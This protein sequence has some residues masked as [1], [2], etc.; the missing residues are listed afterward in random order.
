MCE[1]AA[2]LFLS[3]TKQMSLKLYKYYKFYASKNYLRN[4]KF[5]AAQKK[6]IVSFMHQKKMNKIKICRV[7]F[8][9]LS[10]NLTF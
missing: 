8:F 10:E 6:K 9:F 7:S 5:Y 2:I 1:R 4:Y 3:Q